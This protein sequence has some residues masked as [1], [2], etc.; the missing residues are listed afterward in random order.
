MGEE[1]VSCCLYRGILCDFLYIKR[2][3]VFSLMCW[4]EKKTCTV[5]FMLLYLRKKLICG[6]SSWCVDPI[7]LLGGKV[8]GDGEEKATDLQTERVCLCV[9]SCNH[10]QS[11]RYGAAE[12]CPFTVPVND[13][14]QVF[15]HRWH[16]PTDAEMVLG[17]QI[18]VVWLEHWLVLY[19]F[20]QRRSILLHANVLVGELF[21]GTEL[22][23]ALTERLV[24]KLWW[25][26]IT[27]VQ[28]SALNLIAWVMAG[29]TGHILLCTFSSDL[30][31]VGSIHGE[32]CRNHR[33]K[34]RYR[35]S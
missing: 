27:E 24:F 22:S 12:C 1:K 10:S 4:E 13:K 34:N 25:E 9:P 16:F 11:D 35:Q 7:S 20:L 17:C 33:D 32:S 15:L 26:A 2:H 28:C 23:A 18:L 8:I 31:A 6:P 29:M 3:I 19:N 21:H 5:L 30:T 14:I